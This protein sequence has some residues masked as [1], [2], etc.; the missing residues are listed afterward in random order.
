MSVITCNIKR[1]FPMEIISIKS[2]SLSLIKLWG[3]VVYDV[4][5]S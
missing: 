1:T 3:K 5:Q 2:T 4:E